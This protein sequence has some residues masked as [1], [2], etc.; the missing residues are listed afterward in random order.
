[1][2]E[3]DPQKLACRVKAAQLAILLRLQELRTNL[4]GHLERQ[5]I[6]DAQNGLLVLRKE[7]ARLPTNRNNDP[8]RPGTTNQD[9]YPLPS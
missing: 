6:E 5:A 2:L 3:L 4:D 1:M 8:A 9:T 7:C